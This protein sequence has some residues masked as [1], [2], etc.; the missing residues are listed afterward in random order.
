MKSVNSDCQTD[1]VFV[2]RKKETLQL[3]LQLTMSDILY[4]AHLSHTQ[5]EREICLKKDPLHWDWGLMGFW[6]FGLITIKVNYFF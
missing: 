3:N 1:G 6:G 2:V 4:E 5:R